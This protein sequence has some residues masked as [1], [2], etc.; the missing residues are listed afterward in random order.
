MKKHL[1]KLISAFN[2]LNSDEDRFRF[3][4]EHKGVF[5]LNLDNDDTFTTISDGTFASLEIDR[6]SVDADI[7]NEKITNDFDEYLGWS[8]G[9]FTLLR[10]VG[11]NAA[12]V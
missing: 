7:W 5:K 8:D 3:L 10:V 1:E 4:L 2:F 11:I 6:W 9:I 12:S